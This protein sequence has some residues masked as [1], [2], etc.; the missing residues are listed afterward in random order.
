MGKEISLD[1]GYELIIALGAN[2][3]LHPYIDELY[4]EN[5]MEFY[6]SYIN[7]T[8][9]NDIFKKTLSA[10]QEDI[11]NK[12]SGIYHWC[13][14]NNDNS[15]IINIIK[16]GYNK[17]YRYVLNNEF[18]NVHEFCYKLQAQNKDINE[19]EIFDQA[20]ILIYLCY[21]LNKE[22]TLGQFNSLFAKYQHER[23]VSLAKKNYRQNLIESNADN[24]SNIYEINK[25]YSELNLD[26][27]TFKNMNLDALLDLIV[28][29]ETNQRI[30]EN[31]YSKYKKI[32]DKVSAVRDDLFQEGY[33]KYI[34]SLSQVIEVWGLNP[35]RIFIDVDISKEELDIICLESKLAYEGN[36]LCKDDFKLFIIS[37]LYLFGLSKLYRDLKE[38]YLTNSKEKYFNMILSKETELI[39]KI[40]SIDKIQQSCEIEVS[41]LNSELNCLKKELNSANKTIKKL[42][43]DKEKLE[44]NNK[45]VVALREFIYSFNNEENCSTLCNDEV[46]LIN[47]T[48][49]LKSKSIAVFGGH[50]QWISKL[51][52]QL[53][54]IKFIPIERINVDFSFIYNTDLVVVN[55]IY[56]AHK[57]YKK[58]M[59][60]VE[61]SDCALMYANESNID[62][63]IKTMY[64]QLKLK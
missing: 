41:D 58:L 44:N 5:E 23:L 36:Q 53:N 25:V 49:E 14:E 37:N 15:I 62:K 48:D 56:S 52:N 50:P 3:Y 40:E 19:A 22:Y 10:N 20:H 46:T 63:T 61:K 26:R 45:E 29:T 59:V 64:N 47:M 8:M 18:I 1:I 24:Y 30:K 17:T 35:N 7:S 9:R 33:I 16:K 51:K 34:G 57:L 32:T 55:S 42:T 12:L 21:I 27:A 13:K 6:K 4:I 38:S 28:T 43:S 54:H 60:D 11:V 2:Q 39:N 31:K